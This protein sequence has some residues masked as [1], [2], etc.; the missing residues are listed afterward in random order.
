LA[1]KSQ[2]QLNFFWPNKHWDDL[3]HLLSVCKASPLLRLNCRRPQQ[4]RTA[5][6]W[7]CSFTASLRGITSMGTISV[8]S[9][10]VVARDSRLLFYLLVLE[11]FFLHFLH[12]C[13][14]FPFFRYPIPRRH[15]SG[16]DDSFFVYLLSTL[17]LASKEIAFHNTSNTLTF[18]L[19]TPVSRWKQPPNYPS[20]PP[21]YCAGSSTYLHKSS[22]T[23]QGASSP[24]HF[25]HF[26]AGRRGEEP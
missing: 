15:H 13:T 1:R 22:P 23:A 10:A 21:L 4:Y 12:P 14:T 3:K 26:C 17:L 7:N 16:S 5:V 18:S 8:R 9:I 20:P 25:I 19:V 6:N 2:L 24:F 11:V